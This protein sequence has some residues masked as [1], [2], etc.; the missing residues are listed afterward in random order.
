M[1]GTSQAT[2]FVTGVAALI[3]SYYPQLTAKEL[4]RI[5]KAGAKSIDTLREKCV[6]GGILD[7][8]KAF[9][10]AKRWQAEKVDFSKKRKLADVEVESKTNSK[11]YFLRPK[12]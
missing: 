6:T 4:K 8:E 5:I 11:I 12:G 10:V 2:A 3:K 7:A 1:S 9:E